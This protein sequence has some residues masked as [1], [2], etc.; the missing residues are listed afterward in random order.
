M[1]IILIPLLFGVTLFVQAEQSICFGSS[2][3]GKIIRAVKLPWAG[4]NYTNYST[5][6]VLAGRTYVHSQVKKILVQTYKKLAAQRPSTVYL[7]AETGFYQGGRFRPHKTHQNGLS[8][9]FVVPIVVKGRSVFL[10][11]NAANKWTY[12]I[13]FDQRGR[14]LNY[15]IDF[16]AIAAHIVQ[17]DKTARS[18]K[19]GLRRVLFDPKLQHRLFATKYGAY[20]RRHV[21]FSRRRSWVRHD[22]HYHVD[23][24]V[25]CVNY[26]RYSKYKKYR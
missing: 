3:R 14:Y 5:I 13:D 6:A 21:R 12:G 8:V 11:S 19:L 4:K 18:M 2:A 1:R 7:Y 22:E 9:N 26:S 20:L 10:P 15:Q 16:V 25:P 17:L 23:F 24:K